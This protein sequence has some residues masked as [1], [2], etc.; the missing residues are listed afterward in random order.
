MAYEEQ[1]LCILSDNPLYPTQRLSL[2]Q[3]EI[4]IL[5]KVLGAVGGGIDANRL[6]SFTQ[7]ALSQI[8]L[9]PYQT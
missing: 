5:G 7:E 4:Q 8:P 2:Y 9:K 1:T 6:I 3:E